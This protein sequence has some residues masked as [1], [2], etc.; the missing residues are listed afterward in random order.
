MNIYKLT[1]IK[2]VFCMLNIIVLLILSAVVSIYVTGLVFTYVFKYPHRLKHGT[3][4]YVPRSRF[5]PLLKKLFNHES[6]HVE[7]INY[8]AYAVKEEL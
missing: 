7:S 4:V 3:V 1:Q 8:N 6:P 5:K 2:P